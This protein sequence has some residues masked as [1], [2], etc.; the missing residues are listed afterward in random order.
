MASPIL[1]C[2][3]L[4]SIPIPYK[5]GILYSEIHFG[6]RSLQ[7]IGSGVK[8]EWNG[9]P[10][11]LDPD[12]RSESLAT[13]PAGW[14][15]AFGQSSAAA[16]HLEKQG[17]GEGDLFL[18]FGWFRKTE[19]KDGKLKF[20]RKDIGRHII[21]GW[22]EVGK[23]IEVGRAENDWKLP[24]NLQFLDHHPHVRFAEH[25]RHP[26]RVYV[27]SE[28]GLGAGLFRTESDGL[29]LTK[30]DC[31][32]SQWQLPKGV[33][34]SLFTGRD[35]SYHGRELRWKLGDDGVRLT[36]VSRGQEFVFDGFKHPVA[37][38]YFARLIRTASRKT[39]TCMHEF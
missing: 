12:L 37:Y 22:L 23:V 33:F 13:R 34:D 21:Y 15:A 5:E 6:K 20:C 36:A 4:C 7:Q 26:N 2:G 28:S 31:A 14:R 19:M 29:V 18:F 35:L 39:A 3:C 1:P 24:R 9:G 32:R 11:H 30:P 27:V 8:S 10:A 38:E 25:E 17:V 16:G